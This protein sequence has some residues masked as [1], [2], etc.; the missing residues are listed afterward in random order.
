MGWMRADIRYNDTRDQP[1]FC[2][3]WCFFTT[4]SIQPLYDGM[5]AEAL[6]HHQKLS[7]ISMVFIASWSNEFYSQCQALPQINPRALML[8]FRSTRGLLY[9]VDRHKNNF[10][11]GR[12]FPTYWGS[13]YILRSLTLSSGEEGMGTWKESYCLGKNL[14]RFKEEFYRGLQHEDKNQGLEMI[15]GGS[16]S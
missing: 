10:N 6:L 4:L 11:N 13:F 9:S 7:W 15:K 8:A 3:M 12:I 5:F 16:C 1:Y 14:I 2:V